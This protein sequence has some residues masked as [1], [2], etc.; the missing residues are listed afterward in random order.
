M[1]LASA[2]C[3]DAEPA[4]VDFMMDVQAPSVSTAGLV[5]PTQ[6]AVECGGPGQPSTPSQTPANAPFVPA[7]SVLYATDAK[8]GFT[9]DTSSTPTD[10]M[11]TTY[12]MALTG[13]TL[14][15]TAAYHANASCT[16]SWTITATRNDA[17]SE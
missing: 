5:Q 2:S 9:V 17:P 7:T 10:P 11:I 1:Q 6:V 4:L 12:L 14:T 13:D 15:G 3:G 8:I 16:D